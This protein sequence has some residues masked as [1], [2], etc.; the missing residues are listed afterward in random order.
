MPEGFPDVSDLKP[1]KVKN[2]GKIISSF[3]IKK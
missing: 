1:G 3:Q 2:K